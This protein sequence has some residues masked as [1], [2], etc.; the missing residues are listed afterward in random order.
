MTR[1]VLLML[2]MICL[3]VGCTKSEKTLTIKY[4]ADAGP[5]ERAQITTKALEASGEAL[6]LKRQVEAA[7]KKAQS[8]TERAERA[9]AQLKKLLRAFEVMQ[10]VL[11]DREVVVKESEPP[12]G[13]GEP[14][15]PSG[16]TMR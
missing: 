4:P 1:F 9:E 2:A 3:T 14:R 10:A 15:G 13:K 5:E 16:G 8:A 7:E 6:E 12:R 11:S